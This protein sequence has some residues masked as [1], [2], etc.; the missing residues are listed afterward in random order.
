M[1]E[2]AKGDF[3]FAP[4]EK[5]LEGV[6]EKAPT[7]FENSMARVEMALKKI[8]RLRDEDFAERKAREGVNKGG[9]AQQKDT[10]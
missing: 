2:R 7:R 8:F 10:R 9:V 6:V 5:A 1:G 3:L 4:L